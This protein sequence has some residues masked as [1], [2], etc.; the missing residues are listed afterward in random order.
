MSKHLFVAGTDTGIGKTHGAQALVHA[1]R[2]AGE[3]VAGMKPI[4][5][6]SGRGR[7]GGM[8]NQDAL[9]LQA[10]SSS[11]PDYDLVNPIALEE[12][13][14]PHLAAA[15]SGKVIDWPPLDA[16]FEALTADYER[17]VVEGVG[18]WLVP[19][20]SGM[21]MEDIPMR[22]NLGVVMVVGIRLGCISHARLTARAIEADGCRFAGW[23]ANI[24]E[25]TMPLLEENIAT[26]RECLPA[27]CLGVLP[28]RV[29]PA[30]AAILLDLAMLA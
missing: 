25:P 29:A 9:D 16:A 13:V 20:G 11:P 15:R 27:P 24:V 6:G 26:L 18:G 30:S 21:S 10:A 19:L 22:W 17:V 5:S 28:H 4:A 12:A 3:R 7:G 8:R 2:Q 14:A 1:F 23:I